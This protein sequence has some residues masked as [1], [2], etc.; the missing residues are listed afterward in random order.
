[1]QP[2]SSKLML[3]GNIFGYFTN[4]I[5]TGLIFHKARELGITAIDTADVYSEG[6]SEEY[7]G[8]FIQEDRDKWFIA[9]KAGIRS[10]ASSNGLG[11]KKNIFQKIEGSLQ[12]LKTDYIDLYQIHAFDPETPLEETLEAFSTLLQQGKIRAAG[13]SNY[14]HAHLKELARLP[15]HC[16]TSHQIAMN[17]TNFHTSK[18]ILETSHGLGMSAVAYASLARG[19]FN[20]KYLGDL[21][22]P[23]S[24]AALSQNVLADLTPHFL[25]KLKSTAETVVSYN[26]TCTQV[27]LQWFHQFTN[28]RWVIVGCRNPNQLISAYEAFSQKIPQECIAQVEKIWIDR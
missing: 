6:L 28:V 15:Y 14:T 4:R 17:I 12:R 5:E 10:H 16:F 23:G 13:I 19:I 21:P 26:A 9:S 22:P 7:I 8:S 3:G 18:P 27:A 20:D 25:S 24:R 2:F 1:M 11:K